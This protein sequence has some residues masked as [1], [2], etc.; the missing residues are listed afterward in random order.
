M[1]HDQHQSDNERQLEQQLLGHFRT[2]SQGE[3]SAQID[4]RILAAA[5]AQRPTERAPN[6]LQR[7]STWLS[8]GNARRQRW[9]LALAGVACLGIG[10]SLT[11][12]TLEQA[13]ASY[14]AMPAPM[15]APPAPS[16]ASAPLRESQAEMAS[17]AKALESPAQAQAKREMRKPVVA[18]PAPS[19]FADT[20]VDEPQD[21]LRRLL[22]LRR[23]G[24]DKQAEALRQQL[25]RDYPQLDI[26][27]ALKA[28]EQQP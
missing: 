28:L 7:T 12:R 16:P 6:W 27:A 17:Q 14:D 26:A 20:Q 3:P 11:W 21:S 8:G 9:P 18:E 1:N 4:A 13:P 24:Q 5:R 22:Q 19:A 2:H 25:Q 10:I 23:S 15:S